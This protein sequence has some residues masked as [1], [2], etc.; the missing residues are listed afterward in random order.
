M[1]MRT[2]DRVRGGERTGSGYGVTR[3]GGLLLRLALAASACAALAGT[4]SSCSIIA[5]GVDA[6]QCQA[7]ADCKDFPGLRSCSQNVCVAVT[8]PPACTTVDDCKTYASSVCTGGVCVRGGAC[9]ADADCGSTGITCQSGAC[10]PAGGTGCSKNVDC[11]DN[12]PNYICNKT[13]K[14]CV[15]LTSEL[16]TTVYTTKKTAKDAYQDDSAY[17]F[18]SILPTNGGLDAPFGQ[19]VEN[20]IKLAL[21]DFAAVNGIP[22]A[23]GGASRPLVLIGCNDGENEDRTDEAAKHL[24]EEL[25]ITAIIGYPFSGN[26]ITVATDVTIPDN[27]LLF[28]PSATSAA[29][30]TIDEQH[31]NKD[32]VWR[33]SPSDSFQATALNLYYPEVETRARAKYT[34]SIPANGI[35]V[36]VVNTTDAYGKGLADALE[37]VLQFNGHGATDQANSTFYKRIQYADQASTAIQPLLDFAPNVVFV[38]GFNEGPDTVLKQTESQWSQAGYHPFWI[39]SD[40]GEVG[41]LSDSDIDN[42]DLRQRISGSAPG[43]STDYAPYKAFRSAWLASSYS[44]NGTISPDTLGPAGAYDITY[45]LAYSAVAVGKND[46]TGP[47]LVKYGLRKM[48]PGMNVQKFTIGPVALAQGDIFTKLQS[49][50]AIDIEGTSGPL[51]FDKYGEAASDIQ[52]WCVPPGAMPPVAKSPLNSGRYYSFSQNKMAGTVGTICGWN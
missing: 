48:V 16:C 27:V 28:S 50:Q 26:T 40:G 1:R 5:G 4:A 14:K 17:F 25:G 3:T 35:K 44:A 19:L 52:I 39:F 51:D 7:V 47:N 24:A 10:A 36:A 42:D 18:G 23:T 49:G 34:T 8:A 2:N 21:D 11:A 12:G 22:S 29:I 15:S 46:L 31:G 37:P 20:S 38:F 30:T 6:D 32:L 9:T 33:T 45:M 13:K 43:V 41:S